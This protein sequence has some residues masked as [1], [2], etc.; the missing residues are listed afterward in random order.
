MILSATVL[1]MMMASCGKEPAPSVRMIP[2]DIDVMSAR[3]T[4]SI[5]KDEEVTE[6]YTIWLS[7]YLKESTSDANRG[8]Y[9]VAEPYRKDGGKWSASPVQYWPL[10]SDLD[11]LALAGEEGSFNPEW[12]E[13][14]D[15]NCATA[16]ETDVPDGECLESEILYGAAR[17]LSSVDG[18]VPI[19]FEHSQNWLHFIVNS[20]TDLVKVD[21]IVVESAHAG[22]IMRVTNAIYVGC[23]WRFNTSG[24]RLS[25][26]RVPGSEMAI[27]SD[28]SA[29]CDI[30]LPQQD[31]CDILLY[32]SIK[33]PSDT[34]WS[35]AVRSVYRCPAMKEPWYSG[36][37]NTYVFTFNF[38]EIIFD[39][40]V[41]SWDEN[42]KDIDIE[43]S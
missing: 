1:T 17:N 7:A 10:A 3:D 6:D 11:F 43:L 16:V 25:D 13:W 39:S 9:F 24:H 5:L 8:N 40:W 19:R 27:T 35:E 30:L 20:N 2:I 32:Y 14:Y 21:S 31:A 33:S 12:A 15:V 22:G 23:E 26:V 37:K 28:E 36:M 42:E 18:T 4:K 29:T 38:T 34:D 41:N